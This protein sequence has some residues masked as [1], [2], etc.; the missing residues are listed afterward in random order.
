MICL[1]RKKKSLLDLQI[2][3]HKVEISK[4]KAEIHFWKLFLHYMKKL[5]HIW[6]AFKNTFML[7]YKNQRYN[8]W[9]LLFETNIYKL[10]TCYLY[11]RNN[12]YMV[13]KL[14]VL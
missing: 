3:I 2:R 6:E 5:N 9:A 10:E 8:N 14:F 1:I 12:N 7:F 13:K 4:Q 11:P